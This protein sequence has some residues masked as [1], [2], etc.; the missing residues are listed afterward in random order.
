MS[1]LTDTALTHLR[2]NFDE[3]TSISLF[4]I[5]MVSINDSLNS[6]KKDISNSKL[7]VDDFHALKGVLLNLGLPDLAKHATIL[8]KSAK[9]DTLD[10]HQDIQDSLTTTL[11]QLLEYK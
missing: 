1:E 8:Q 7:L 11:E 5:A 3:E 4:D 6:I 2:A 9:E 10:N